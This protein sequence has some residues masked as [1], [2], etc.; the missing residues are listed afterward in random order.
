MLHIAGYPGTQGP[1]AFVSQV[2][3]TLPVTGICHST[4]CKG[5]SWEPQ[6]GLHNGLKVLSIEPHFPICSGSSGPPSKA[7]S[8]LPYIVHIPLTEKLAVHGHLTYSASR[9]SLL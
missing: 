5:D 2:P 3:G 8:Q 1:P 9:C 7:L 6:P 4:R